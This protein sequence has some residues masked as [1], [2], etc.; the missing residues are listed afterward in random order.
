MGRVHLGWFTNF[1]PPSW[2]RTW[3]GRAADTWASGQFHINVARRLEEG[4]LDYLLLEDSS[5]VSNAYGGEFELE[6]RQMSRAPKHDPM[7]LVAAMA[8]ETRHLG[9]VATA[10]T[11]YY[12][13]FLLARLMSTL[14]HISGGRAGWNIVTGGPNQALANFGLDQRAELKDSASAH[15]LRYDIADEFA[16]VVLKLWDSWEADAVIADREADRYIESAKVHTIDHVGEHFRSRGPLNTIPSPQHRP[17]ICQAGGSPRGI[18]FAA[19]YADTIVALPKGVE[20]MTSY[21]ADVRRSLEEQGRDPHSVKIMFLVSPTLGDDDADARRRRDADRAR[22][23]ERIRQRLSLMSGGD[24]DWSTYPLDE[25][26]P[27][28]DKTGQSSSNTFLRVNAGKTFRQALAEDTTEAVELVGAP[29]TVAERMGEVAEATGG[30][31][32][33]FYSGSGQL[34]MRYVDEVIDGLVPALQRAGLARTEYVSST[35]RE[36]LQEF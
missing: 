25:P 24:E 6:L 13:P 5:Y 15:D 36:T 21:V 33:L 34:T 19:K 9:L 28:L 22:V 29:E 16:D 17:A 32:F 20:Y 12:S 2:N 8:R 3:S 18:A 4:C 14:D 10:N 31:G 7:P 35:L 1:L 23:D 30:D 26:L 11:T 27:D